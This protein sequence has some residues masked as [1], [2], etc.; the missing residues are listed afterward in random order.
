M[1]ED[2]GLLKEFW[3]KKISKLSG[4][5]GPGFI[6]SFKHEFEIPV[7]VEEALLFHQGK[8]GSIKGLS[9]FVPEDNYWLVFTF[10]KFVSIDSNEPIAK[11]LIDSHD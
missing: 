9:L 7:T 5:M 10:G 2:V 4:A 1:C 8:Y 3:T 6:V 11:L